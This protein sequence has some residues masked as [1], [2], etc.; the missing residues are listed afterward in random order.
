M[1]FAQDLFSAD[2]MQFAH[3]NLF[4]T[5]GKRD[6]FSLVTNHSFRLLRFFFRLNCVDAL[7][8]TAQ[9]AQKGKFCDEKVCFL[10]C[11]ISSVF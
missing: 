8:T 3:E 5:D 11:R 10:D 7:K 4:T 1:V 6:M 9:F 2:A